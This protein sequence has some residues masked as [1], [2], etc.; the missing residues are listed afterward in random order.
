MAKK[1][2]Q[3]LM[4]SMEQEQDKLKRQHQEILAREAALKKRKNCVLSVWPWRHSRIPA[5]RK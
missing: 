5:A 4:E 3:S 1:Q 2:Q